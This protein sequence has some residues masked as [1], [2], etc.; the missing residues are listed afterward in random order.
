[1]NSN[2]IVPIV[3]EG[4]INI[5]CRNEDPRGRLLSNLINRPF[6]MNDQ[7]CA[8][9]EGFFAGILYPPN[10]EEKERAFASCYTYAQKMVQNA[11]MMYNRDKVWWNDQELKY[12]STE[13]KQLLRE[14]LLQCTLQNPDRLEALKATK[15]YIL[16]HLTGTPE[17]PNNFL[18]RLEFCQ[19]MTE[20]REQLLNV[21]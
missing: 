18:S 20:I 16:R 10:N 9:V 7:M 21:E 17:D 11:H 12:G 19:M 4:E 8:S 1:M 15:G 5:N 14:A 3:G 13:H 6:R 2:I